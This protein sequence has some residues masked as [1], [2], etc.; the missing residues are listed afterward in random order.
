MSVEVHSPRQPAPFQCRQARDIEMK[1]AF[2]FLLSTAAGSFQ[3][4]GSP[5]PAMME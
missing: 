3:L 4:I 2:L 5:S 1:K